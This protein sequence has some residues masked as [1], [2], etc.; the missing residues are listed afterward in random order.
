MALLIAQDFGFES[1][2]RDIS[3]LS[4]GGTE[5]IKVLSVK[6]VGR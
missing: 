5:D 4:R 6:N 1:C 3:P 2:C